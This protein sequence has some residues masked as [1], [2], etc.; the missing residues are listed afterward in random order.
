MRSRKFD[1]PPNS[2]VP[3]LTH[4]GSI[5]KLLSTPALSFTELEYNFREEEPRCYYLQACS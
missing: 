3:S 4:L 5:L 2:G 1:L